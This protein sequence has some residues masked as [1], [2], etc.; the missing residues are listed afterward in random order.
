MFELIAFKFFTIRCTGT[1]GVA[2]RNRCTWSG[3]ISIDW[4]VQSKDSAI[5]GRISFNFSSMPSTRTFRRYFG[6]Q[7]MW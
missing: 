7:I 6:H 4:T 5:S 3:I 2:F 1:I